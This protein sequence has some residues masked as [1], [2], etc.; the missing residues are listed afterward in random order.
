MGLKRSLDAH[1]GLRYAL[2]YERAQQEAHG[3]KREAAYGRFR[4][5]ST[6]MDFY[7]SVSEVEGWS[8]TG[9]AYKC[10]LAGLLSFFGG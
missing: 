7:G 10:D 3:F 6:A 4:A 8:S 5:R 2:R 1:S 9:H